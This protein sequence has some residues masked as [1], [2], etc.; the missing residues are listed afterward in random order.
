MYYESIEDLLRKY[1]VHNPK[2]RVLLLRAA[3]NEIDHDVRLEHRQKKS[4]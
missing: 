3:V 2:E 4:R 1:D